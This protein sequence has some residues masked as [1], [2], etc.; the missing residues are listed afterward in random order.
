MND[1]KRFITEQEL[2]S[3]Y[4]GGSYDD[5]VDV[6]HQYRRATRYASRK[7]VGSSATASAL[8]LP[9]SRLRTWIDGDGK[10][11]FVRAID[12][13]YQKGWIECTYQ[14]AVFTG[15]N[16]LV[17]NVF[18]GGSISRRTR[19]PLFALNHRGEDSHVLDAL[20]LA[21]VDYDIVDDRDGRADEVRP[22][23]G[24]TV[25]G[26]VLEVL[27]APVGAKAE[28]QLSLPTYLEF[29][30]DDIRESFVYAYLENRAIEHEQKDTLTIVEERNRTYLLELTALIEDVAGGGVNLGEHN[31]VISA[32][33]ARRL[34]TVR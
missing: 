4:S 20:K 24:A 10:P 23:D 31:I 30:P 17:A 1:V 6:L 28:Q 34:G 3:T 16:T 22:N 2:A 19:V 21:G 18:S 12:T 25:L 8:D 26:R 13:A 15:L 14:D 9:R 32:D 33:A 5:P 7:N 11:D 29:A 27:G